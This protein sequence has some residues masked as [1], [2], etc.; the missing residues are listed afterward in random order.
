MLVT[1]S[2]HPGMCRP[3]PQGATLERGLDGAIAR[4]AAEGTATAVLT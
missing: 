1:S 2:E 4:F 3:E